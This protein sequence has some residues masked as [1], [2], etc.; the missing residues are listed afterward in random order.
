[1]TKRRPI[2]DFR[3]WAAPGTDDTRCRR[4]DGRVNSTPPRLRTAPGQRYGSRNGPL[5]ALM[6]GARLNCRTDITGHV[7]ATT[8][9]VSKLLEALLWQL[10]RISR[11]LTLA[12]SGRPQA[13]QARGRRNMAGAPRA[14]PRRWGAPPPPRARF[15]VRRGTVCRNSLVTW[16][17]HTRTTHPP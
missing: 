11:C 9:D 13:L 12:L 4:M 6:N 17:A 3:G 15:W 2:R 8:I 16:P 10:C 1:M 7:A 5:R 14:R